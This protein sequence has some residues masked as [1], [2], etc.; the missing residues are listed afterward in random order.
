MQWAPLTRIESSRLVLR[1]FR[2]GDVEALR[3][4]RN[5]PE[6]ARFQG[7]EMPF[8]RRDALGLI[9]E[10]RAARPGVPG[11]RFEFAAALRETDT[12]I[13][14]CALTVDIRDSRQAEISFSFARS[15]HGK[16]FASEA[17]CALIDFA[18]SHHLGLHRIVAVTRCENAA[19]IALLERLGF[20]LEGRTTASV[21]SRGRWCDECLFA[22]LESEWN[23]RHKAA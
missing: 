2:E 18:F 23:F 11:C 17:V 12:L 8:R 15:Y 4:Y 6:V 7:W 3:A 21:W 5:D 1:K 9:G 14:D 20:R 19:A 22:M 16:G 10:H 13:G